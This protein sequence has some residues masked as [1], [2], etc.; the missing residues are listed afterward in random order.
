MIKVFKRNTYEEKFK[1]LVAD[2]YICHAELPSGTGIRFGVEDL[3]DVK[4]FLEDLG[5]KIEGI[6]NVE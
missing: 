1:M 2:P 4:L 5:M 3:K 6:I